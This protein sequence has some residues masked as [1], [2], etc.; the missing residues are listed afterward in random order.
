MLCHECYCSFACPS[1][2]VNHSLD[3]KPLSIRDFGFLELQ[4]NQYVFCVVILNQ[5]IKVCRVDTSVESQALEIN[6]LPCVVRIFDSASF[7]NYH[8]L[9]C[10]GGL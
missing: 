2:V 10:L 7:R 1:K 5:S 4:L 8:P 6:E 3:C 9:I